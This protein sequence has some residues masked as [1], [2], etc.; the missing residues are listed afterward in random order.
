V[1]SK[2]RSKKVTKSEG[3]NDNAVQYLKK[4]HCPTYRR[5]L[6]RSSTISKKKRK[7]KTI[8]LL[9]KFLF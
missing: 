7:E 9:D 2:S 3:Y 4:F 8:L 5:T 1:I 6:L